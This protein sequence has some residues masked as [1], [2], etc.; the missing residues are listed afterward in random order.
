M[1]IVVT[2][3]CGINNIWFIKDPLSSVVVCGL[4]KCGILSIRSLL[5]ARCVNNILCGQCSG[6]R[7][8][9]FRQ[10]RKWSIKN[11]TM[12]VLF[13]SPYDRCLSA[14]NDMTRNRYIAGSFG[15][16]NNLS[17]FSYEKFVNY[18]SANWRTI[19]KN[20]H[21]TPQTEICQIRHI[22][23]DFMG[24]LTNSTDYHYFWKVLLKS[25]N[26]VHIHQKSANT[27]TQNVTQETQRII[28][29]LYKDDFKF[30][31]DS[32]FI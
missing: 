31:R 2:L 1:I 32:L 19:R 3:L 7:C 11:Q 27:L 30:F 12:A 28:R 21:F 5:N 4:P 13:R 23:Y 25:Q 20:E 24:Y 8:A 17:E 26:E 10:N 16:V 6:N 22:K 9:E 18:L 14:Y 29:D 15:S